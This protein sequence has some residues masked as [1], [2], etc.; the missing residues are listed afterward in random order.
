M[1]GQI[2]RS[3]REFDPVDRLSGLRQKIGTVTITGGDI[4]NLFGLGIVLGQAVPSQV[5]LPYF[6]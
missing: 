6:S 1:P 5:I 2:Y 4:E 3:R